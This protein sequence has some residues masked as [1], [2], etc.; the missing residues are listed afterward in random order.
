MCVCVCVCIKE[1]S[2]GDEESLYGILEKISLS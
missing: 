2:R 1:L